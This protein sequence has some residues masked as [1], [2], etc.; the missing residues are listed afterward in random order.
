M[1]IEDT[2]IA[3]KEAN[4]FVNEHFKVKVRVKTEM[5][6]NIPIGNEF[7]PKE[8]I[9]EGDPYIKKFRF[10]QFRDAILLLG[11]AAAKLWTWIE[12]NLPHGLDY[13]DIKPDKFCTKANVTRRTY[14]TAL[15]QL[16]E[17]SFICASSIQDVVFINPRLVFYGSRIAKYPAHLKY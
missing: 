15:R 6:N 12:Y 11:P 8:T 14:T 1:N 17:S 3:P 13:I 9:L 5:D 7:L 10:M 4:P 16:K 2:I